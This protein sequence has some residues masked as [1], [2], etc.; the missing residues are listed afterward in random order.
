MSKCDCEGTM[1][2]PYEKRKKERVRTRVKV[3]VV[4][5]NPEEAKPSRT[6]G[7]DVSVSGLAFLCDRE[8]AAGTELRVELPLP[9]TTINLSSIVVRSELTENA[10]Q[11]RVAVRFEALSNESLRM[12]GWFVKEEGRKQLLA[13][14]TQHPSGASFPSSRSSASDKSQ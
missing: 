12:L 2:S 6:T 4:P 9:N 13:Q 1:Q 8:Y 3:G 10:D 11:W 7:I 5:Q 14:S